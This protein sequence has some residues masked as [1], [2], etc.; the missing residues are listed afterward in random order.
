MVRG[1]LN[2]LAWLEGPLKPTF[3][4]EN[5]VKVI[6]SPINFRDI[7]L[8]TGKLAVEVIAKT[9]QLQEC[10]IGFEYCGIDGKGRRVMGMLNTRCLTNLCI[11]ERSLCWDVPES[12]SLEDA[13]TV[14]CVYGTC[15]YALYFSGK[16]KKGDTVLI[17]AG[18]G[19]V[20]QAAINLALAEGCEIFTTVGTPE[21]RK[22]IRD[23]FPQIPDDHIGNS[24]DTSFE[25]MIIRKTDGRGVDIV[26]NSL[27]EEKLQASVRC[28]ARGGR[29]LEIGKFDLAA[30]NPLGMEAFLKEISFHGIML[31]NLFT[32]PEEKKIELKGFLDKYLKNGAVKPLTRTVFPKDQ[33]E[34]AFRYMAAGKH[35]GKVIINVR[36]KDDPLEGLT[37]ALPR[38]HCLEGHS[39]VLL[40]GLGGFGLELA[41][42][43]VLRGAQNL[44]L[45]SR[46]GIKTGYQ[47]M[48]VELW[49]SYG[50][51]VNIVAGKDASKR[52]DCESILKTAA[53]LGPVDGIFNLA[54]VL[55]D[56]L[57]ENQTEETFEESF[58]SKAW[59]TKQL[60]ELSRKI[61][62]KLRHFVVFSS[63]SCGRGNAGQTNYGMSNS[64]MER[65]C[66]RRATEGLPALAVQWGAVGD[67]GLVAEMQEDHKE[68]VIGGTLQQTILSC[69]KELDGFLQQ[70]KPIVSSMVVAEKRAGGAGATNIVDAVL[71]IMGKH[72][73]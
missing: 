58:R 15:V 27:A 72:F 46:T 47:R 10:V 18:T 66:E 70:D 39:Y 57:W 51:K 73:F 5:L 45:T 56:S 69:L 30:N 35:V 9:R 54:V 67:V 48:R 23:T 32:A 65:I 7:M 43:L 60:D 42:W 1:D 64:V 2:S 8:T 38:Y 11:A 53:Q 50:V 13:A 71:N 16:M 29:F 52:E 34:A 40:G 59:S 14:P 19:G 33:V 22:F 44:V 31:D 61:C 12:W 20:G 28:L 3:N 49:E 55:K 62:P 68:L 6:Y 63:V 41:D 26:L 4:D 17:H 21:K 37:P 24:R 25:Q 36:D